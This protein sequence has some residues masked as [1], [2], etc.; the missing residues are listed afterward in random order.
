VALGA[1]AR[2]LGAMGWLWFTVGH[3]DA[4]A[5]LLAATQALLPHE[6]GNATV[7]VPAS[8]FT[9]FLHHARAA[10]GLPALGMDPPASRP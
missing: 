4:V 3:L 6:S 10:I 7:S 1:W 2:R 8:F 5:A 9:Q